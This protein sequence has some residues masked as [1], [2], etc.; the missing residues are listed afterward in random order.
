MA[1]S[2][3]RLRLLLSAVVT[4]LLLVVL[5]VGA[6]LGVEFT[7]R[8]L[9]HRFDQLHKAE[10]MG[11]LA[12][13]E[14]QSRFAA[15]YLDPE[16]ALEEMHAY[17]WAVPSVPTPFVGAAPRPGSYTGHAIGANQFR[18]PDRV[19][20]TRPPGVTRV[21]ITGGSTAFGVGAPDLERTIGGYLERLL[22]EAADPRRFE[23][24]TFANPAWASTHERIAIENRLSEM[25]FDLVISFSG[26][27]DIHWSLRGKNVLWFQTYQDEHFS[28]L[29]DTVQL[30]YDEPRLVEVEEA[31]DEPVDVELLVDRIEKNVRLAA[32]ALEM[33]GGRYLYA[34][35]PST[36]TA[37]KNATA[38]WA[39]ATADR[40][41]FRSAYAQ[42]HQRLGSLELP[43]FR[44]VDMAGVFDDLDPAQQVFLDTYHFADLGNEIVAR[45][46]RKSVLELLPPP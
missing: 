21:A 13:P 8:N 1:S 31:Q 34:L 28:F 5:G 33:R 46:L 2:E 9:R 17:L 16:A 44:F 36:F 22:N 10:M 40:D 7:K 11:G 45:G 4:V 42:I 39:D 30:A 24:Y 18:H 37:R 15:A 26:I 35:Q 19:P 25:Q 43:N 23:V 29:I 20:A 12:S 38:D 6:Y 32:A 14:Q 41:Y 3:L 27:N